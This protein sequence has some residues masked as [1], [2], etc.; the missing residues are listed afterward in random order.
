MSLAT[1]REAALFDLKGARVYVA[2][3]GGMVGSAI[4]RRLQTEDCT[5]LTANRR[6]LDL[7]RQAETVDSPD[8][9]PS[10]PDSELP[11]GVPAPYWLDLRGYDPA[12]AATA[13]NK[14]ILIVQGARDYQVTIDDDLA[15]WKAALDGRPGVTIRVYDA[16][17]HLFVPG[18][19]PSGPAEYGTAQH[20]DPAVVADIADWLA[21]VLSA[22]ATR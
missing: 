5:V 16:D 10:T 3:H 20:M 21:A 12:A 13:L 7:T 11:F 8:L 9:S 6:D 15:G 4:V 19:G 14:P 1:E 17:N 18:S 2:G 22:P